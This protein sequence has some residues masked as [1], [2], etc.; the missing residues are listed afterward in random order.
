MNILS[1]NNIDD[2]TQTMYFSFGLQ[3]INLLFL[4][5]PNRTLKRRYRL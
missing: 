2:V 4:A 1:S 3:S 5:T